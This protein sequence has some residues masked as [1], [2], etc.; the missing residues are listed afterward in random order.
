MRAAL[1]TPWDNAWVPLLREAFERRG[2]GFSH[3]KSERGTSGADVV[4]HGWASGATQPVEGARN[5]FWCRRYEVFDGGL[6]RVDWSRADHLV[7]VNSWIRKYVTNLF[8]QMRVSVPVSLIYNGT[9]PARW[10]YRERRHAKRIGMAC[11]VHPKKNLGLALQVLEACGDG[12]ELHIAGGIQDA[13]TVEYLNAMASDLGLKVYLYGHLE[14][15][16]LDEWWEQFPFCLSTSI[17]EGNP[18]NVIEAMAK[19]IKPVV[20][21]WPGARDQFGEWVWHTPRQAAE[22]MIGEPHSASYLDHVKKH[23]GLGNIEAVVDL[24]ERLHG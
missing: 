9:D 14:R 11:H 21:A 19:G 22:M 3:H 12:W 13:C 4:L 10:R 8:A 16:H 23:F 17:S 24:A 7:V 15:E 2:H 6:M 18:N 5:I 20:H 1:V